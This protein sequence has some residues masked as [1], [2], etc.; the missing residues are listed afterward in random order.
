MV[1]LNSYL[2]IEQGYCF[3][4]TG[5]KTLLLYLYGQIKRSS[6]LKIEHKLNLMLY[7][8]QLTGTRHS[9]GASLDL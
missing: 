1:L 6:R 2:S 8:T 7:Q 3:G 5:V 9:F 4:A